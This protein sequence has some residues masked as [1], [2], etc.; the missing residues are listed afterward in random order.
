MRK[1]SGTEEQV[2]KRAYELWVNAGKPEGRSEEFWHAAS[3]EL[4]DEAPGE[5]KSGGR[6]SPA[7]PARQRS[8]RKTAPV[9]GRRG[10]AKSTKA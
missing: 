10:S 5:E 8:P 2:R 6:D 7:Q 1:M 4:G 9:S 3:A